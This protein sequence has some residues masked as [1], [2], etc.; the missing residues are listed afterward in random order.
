MKHI[1]PFL[2]CSALVLPT[3]QAQ[4]SP[5]GKVQVTFHD[6]ALTVSC[7]HAGQ[8]QQVM[9]L[10]VALSTDKALTT[11]A[12]ET[13]VS[14]INDVI[15]EYGSAVPAAFLQNAVIVLLDE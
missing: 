5:N 6:G 13:Y 10:P 4:T 15:A 14:N 7:L 3:L 8:R 12:G 9:S 11:E 1:L 2:F